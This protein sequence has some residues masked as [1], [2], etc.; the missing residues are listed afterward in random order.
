MEKEKPKS[1]PLKI[2][3]AEIQGYMRSD[4]QAKKK[5]VNSGRAASVAKYEKEKGKSVYQSL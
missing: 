5:I 1:K 2:S 3:S 4:I